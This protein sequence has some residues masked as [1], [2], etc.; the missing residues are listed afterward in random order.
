MKLRGGKHRSGASPVYA[1]LDNDKFSPLSSVANLDRTLLGVQP[2]WR[3]NGSDAT[4]SAWTPWTDGESLAVVND[5]PDVT[6]GAGS[7]LMGPSTVDGSVRFNSGDYFQAAGNTFAQVTT[8]D[9]V[10]EFIGQVSAATK[11]IF[12]K[13]TGTAGAGGYGFLPVAAKLK[14]LVDDDT[15]AIGVE[16]ATLT[17]GAWYHAICFLDHSGSAQWYV[18]G[19][20]SGAPVSLAAHAASSWTSTQKLT[21][22]AT[23]TGA[24]NYDKAISYM[25]MW[26][27]DAWLPEIGD[28]SAWAAI[29]AQRF[30]ALTGFRP[31]SS[32]AGR[33]LSPVT[34]QRDSVATLEKLESD[35]T[36]KFYSVGPHW[37]R[38][39]RWR[40]DNGRIVEGYRSELQGT[41]IATLST[42]LAG[43][44]QTNVTVAAYDLI[45]IGTAAAIT[46][47]TA[48]NHH[49]IS[50]PAATFTNA[51]KY[52]MSCIMK[53]GAVRNVA[54]CFINNAG[55]PTWA[56]VK[57][58]TSTIGYS[59][60][61]DATGAFSIGGGRTFFWGTWTHN[62]TESRGAGFVYS[63]SGDN[64]SDPTADTYVGVDTGVAI[65]ANGYQ[66]ELGTYPS[67]LIITAASQAIRNKDEV[68]MSPVG[69]GVESSLQGAMVCD[70][71]L[72]NRASTLSEGFVCLDDGGSASDRILLYRGSLAEQTGRAL[73]SASG[74]DGGSAQGTS[75]L[76]N[77][78]I[79]RVGT[80]WKKDKLQ[81][82]VDGV[83][84]A[85]DLA[86][87]I[88]DDIDNLRI[89]MNNANII[90]LGGLIRRIRIYR[91]FL[92]DMA[93]KTKL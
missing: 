87:D 77:G 66:C 93:K 62:A 15:T 46:E 38:C 73:I 32:A 55:T 37:M 52:V 23:Y 36:V 33:D 25:A 16:T 70:V 19:K 89:G 91:R 11:Y 29:A 9:M 59:A 85:E 61:F 41:N 68:V 50:I 90:Q 88:P 64:N 54:S 81:I 78:V 10:F 84:E 44:T 56:N 72:K 14:F 39:E 43:W 17:G 7:P 27:S 1:I 74:G 79:H 18:N 53:A 71:L 26:K 28:G 5:G 47:T 12:N 58:D 42:N 34:F 30:R 51:T 4:T 8:E 2:T 80:T 57:L 24:L 63:R 69:L 75:D 21:I 92:D 13:Y 3:Y 20:T 22:G 31:Q 65:Y 67:S 6:P 40:D 35:G 48:N 49:R 45:G 82:W 60:G 83:M 76:S 86:V